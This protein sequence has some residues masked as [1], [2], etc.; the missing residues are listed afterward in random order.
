LRE[1]DRSADFIES[2]ALRGIYENED[3]FN[4]STDEAV[5]RG[6]PRPGS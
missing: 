1:H 5:A 2:T 3:E 4:F 6:R